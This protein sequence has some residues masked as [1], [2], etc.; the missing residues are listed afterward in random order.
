MARFTLGNQEMVM[1]E[2]LSATKVY[3][4]CIFQWASF[5]LLSFLSWFSGK[6]T[7]CEWER[8]R[9]LRQLHGEQKADVT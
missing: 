5:S 7:A 1:D 9:L 3:Y 8:R 6:L 2:P 4:L